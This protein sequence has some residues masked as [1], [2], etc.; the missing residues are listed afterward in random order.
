[1]E[2]VDYSHKNFEFLPKNV[3]SIH[4]V[5]AWLF[6][7]KREKSVK[8]QMK[9]ELENLENGEKFNAF[10][11]QVL[12]IKTEQLQIGTTLKINGNLQIFLN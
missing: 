5:N 11:W 12:N 7:I 1:M 2:A 3:V 6:C 8:R 10:E 9:F 4:I